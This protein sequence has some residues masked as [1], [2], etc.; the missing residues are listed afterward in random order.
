MQR[1]PQ[2]PK[3]LAKKI[4][5]MEENY[6]EEDYPEDASVKN[7]TIDPKEYAQVEKALQEAFES[8][9][10]R[11]VLRCWNTMKKFEKAPSVSL[12]QVVESM[13][14]FK[15]DTPFIL[16]ELKGFLK[17]FYQDRAK[18][19]PTVENV[20]QPLKQVKTLVSQI[21]TPHDREELR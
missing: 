9:D 13:Q 4:K 14:R 15:K 17:K 19:R 7:N 18:L 6:K 3:P 16:R 20:T 10:Y 11:A 2:S 8:G 21:N 12:P 5:L 1:T